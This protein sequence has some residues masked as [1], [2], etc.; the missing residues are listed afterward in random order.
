MPFIERAGPRQDPAPKLPKELPHGLIVPPAA[1]L[2]RTE[3][4]RARHAPDVF[5]KNEMRLLNDWTIGHVFDGLCLE[6]VYR[7]TPK[8][9]EVLAVGMEEVDALKKATPLA[10]QKKFQTFLGY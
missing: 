2:E 4:E 9:P 1:V 8:G 5:A 3:Q 7:P 10:E 6:V